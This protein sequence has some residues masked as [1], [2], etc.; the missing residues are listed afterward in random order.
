[1]RRIGAVALAET[2]AAAALWGTSF[3]VNSVVIRSG[4]DPRVFALLRFAVAAPIMLAACKVSGRSVGAL[5]KDRAVWLISFFN[6]LGIVCQFIGQAYTDASTAALLVNL[7]VVI[8][9][10][11]SGLFLKE[12]FTLTKGFGVGLAVLGTVLLTTKGDLSLISN[13]QLLGDALYLTAAVS[14]GAYIVYA[15][16]KVDEM[17]LEPF[18]FST[19]IVALSSLFILPVGLTG[20]GG[21][22][23]S[24]LSLEAVLYTALFNTAIPYVLYQAGLRHLTATTSAVVLLLEIVTAVLI[25]TFYLG[26]SLGVL[27]SL[28][29]AFVLVSVLLVSGLEVSGKSLSVKDSSVGRT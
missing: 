12:R 6:A 28:G 16:K 21:L 3:P 17:H 23:L 4:L 10:V 11:G 27:S 2:A 8:A 7:S 1:M 19:S 22:V 5:M 26:E 15:K 24:Q 29:A 20:A 18:A 9:A 13:T 25:S 14:W